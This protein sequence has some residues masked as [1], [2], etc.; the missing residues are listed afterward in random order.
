MPA[1]P[2]R[3]VQIV[4]IAP[5]LILPFA[6]CL[7]TQFGSPSRNSRR[8]TWSNL[9]DERRGTPL[10][11]GIDAVDLASQ[12]IQHQGLVDL[13]STSLNHGQLATPIP[14]QSLPPLAETIKLGTLTPPN[15]VAIIPD[16]ISL[17]G[18]L[19]R[20][21]NPLIVESFRDLFNGP[22]KA[23]SAVQPNIRMGGEDSI[24]IPS[25]EFDVVGRYA[26]LLNRV[27]LA[28]A[29]YALVDFF[30]VN[31][32]EDVAIAE[33]L[34]DTEGDGIMEMEASVVKTRFFG[35]FVTVVA[36]VIV[37]SLIYHPVPFNEL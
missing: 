36:T 15:E 4:Y 32:E 2:L 37:S 24:F 33:L 10:S 13:V 14:N 27:P 5:I 18:G 28:A 17:P 25:R 23:S 29:I 22:I 20:S 30:F 11:L 35:L 9:K 6:S 21:G 12:H 1:S 8:S 31:A 34:D 16:Q 26:D 3:T 7:L 19:P